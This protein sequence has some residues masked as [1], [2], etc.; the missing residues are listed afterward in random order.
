[1]RISDWSSDVCSS[2]LPIVSLAL[3][4]QGIDPEET[5]HCS[6]GLR[7]GNRVFRCWKRG[8]HGLVNMARGIYQSCDVY[9]YHFAQRVG[10]DP[11]AAMERRCGLGAAFPLPVTSQFF[12]TGTSPVW[13]PA[14]FGRE[15]ATC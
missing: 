15:V 13:T 10:I 12:G 3:L 5:I 11:I 14:T 7:V 2:D 1:M 8:G 9:F 4:N 6:G